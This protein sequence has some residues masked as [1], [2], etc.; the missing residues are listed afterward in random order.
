[1]TRYY[2][3]VIILMLAVF[4]IACSGSNAAKKNDL[5]PQANSMNGDSSSKNQSEVLSDLTPTIFEEIESLFKDSSMILESLQKN[6]KGTLIKAIIKNDNAEKN[7]PKAIK[8]LSENFKN[9]KEIHVVLSGSTTVYS[10]RM[11][12]IIELA[13]KN[14][15]NALLAE[16][17]ESVDFDA[18]DDAIEEKEDDS[19]AP[20]A[21]L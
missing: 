12:T 17:W 6:K 8:I 5:T 14:S 1:M 21:D 13:E 19:A 18:A 2:A 15:G 9:L 11:D 7:V 20:A 3:C 10:I 4:S 16:I